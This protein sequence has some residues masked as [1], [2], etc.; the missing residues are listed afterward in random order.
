M[1]IPETTAGTPISSLSIARI[2]TRALGNSISRS[3]RGTSW[4]SLMIIEPGANGR[5]S[6]FLPSASKCAASLNFT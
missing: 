1:M 2:R 5:S 6:T 3:A 4:N